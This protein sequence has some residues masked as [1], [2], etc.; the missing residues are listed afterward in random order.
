MSAKLLAEVL[1]HYH[2][3]TRHKLWLL[4]FAEFAN[5]ETRAAWPSRRLLAWRV[6]VSESRASHIASAL[7]AEGVIKRD[8]AGRKGR[9]STRYVL[10]PLSG[11]GVRPE[12]T[13]TDPDE[14]APW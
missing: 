7:V 5:D 3:P 6:D 10:V 1:D 12:R 11:N 4:A 9:G 2:G 13:L 14:E 8:E